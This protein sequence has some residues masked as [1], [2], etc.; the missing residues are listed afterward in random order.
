[1]SD[2]EEEEEV[3][4]IPDDTYK[5]LSLEKMIALIS[6]L[7]EKSR[8]ADDNQ[9]QISDKDYHCIIS[10]NKVYILCIH[11]MFLFIM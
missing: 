10:A 2:D 6:L 3:I 11:T 4:T 9:L 5:P 7:V 1:L 8:S